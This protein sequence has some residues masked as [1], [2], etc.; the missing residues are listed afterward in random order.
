MRQTTDLSEWQE[1]NVATGHGKLK[2]PHHTNKTFTIK[3]LVV[4][5]LGHA[6]YYTI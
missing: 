1:S 4:L 3:L 6:V 5:V 2:F